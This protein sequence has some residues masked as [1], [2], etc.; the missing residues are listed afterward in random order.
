MKDDDK[1][2]TEGDESEAAPEPEA[3]TDAPVKKARSKID[4]IEV[5]LDDGIDPAEV[6]AHGA[7]SRDDA[8]IDWDAVEAAAADT[9]RMEN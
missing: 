2:I 5:D 7:E 9:S 1:T 8:Q 4:G 6:E 3:K